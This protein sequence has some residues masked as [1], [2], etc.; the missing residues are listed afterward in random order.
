VNFH[1]VIDRPERV[2]LVS[3]PRTTI[4]NT[5]AA[6]PPSHSERA[7]LDP[8]LRPL[9]TPCRCTTCKQN[10]M[11]TGRNFHAEQELLASPAVRTTGHTRRN[12]QHSFGTWRYMLLS[13]TL[14]QVR[15]KAGTM[16][17]QCTYC[18]ALPQYFRA[19]YPFCH[20]GISSQV[21]KMK[22]E[23]HKNAKDARCCS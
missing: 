22:A 19:S 2:S 5:Q 13:R 6:H 10:L 3:P 15:I 18:R 21:C 12:T 11:R 1:S 9:P 14:G 23:F 16:I 20:R 4:L 8:A 17:G 7:F